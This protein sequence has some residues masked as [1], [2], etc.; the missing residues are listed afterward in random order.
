[1]R[2]ILEAVKSISILHKTAPCETNLNNVEWDGRKRLKIHIELHK[3][4]FLSFS[5]KK[6]LAPSL[7]TDLKEKNLDAIQEKE[8]KSSI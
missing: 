3:T 4:G 5:L 7:L 1:M 8:T 6:Y 2:K